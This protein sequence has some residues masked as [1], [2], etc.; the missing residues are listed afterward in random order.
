MLLHIY[1]FVYFIFLYIC[2]DKIILYNL[3]KIRI[4]SD[5]YLRINVDIFKNKW[6]KYI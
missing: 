3:L 2:K 4:I 5:I 1:K 6:L